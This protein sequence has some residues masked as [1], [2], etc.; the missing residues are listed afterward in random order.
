MTKIEAAAA[1]VE[2]C[3]DNA[4]YYGDIAAN[5]EAVA[6]ACAALIGKQEEVSDDA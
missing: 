4:K 2:M 6:M 1:L 3:A 5:Y